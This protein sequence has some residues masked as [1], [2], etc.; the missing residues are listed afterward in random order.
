VASGPELNAALATIRVERLGGIP[1]DT[2]HAC[3]ARATSGH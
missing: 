2:C 3:P 1:C